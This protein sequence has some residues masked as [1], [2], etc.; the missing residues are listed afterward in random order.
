MQ[1]VLKEKNLNIFANT[2]IILFYQHFQK[3]MKQKE[4]EKFSQTLKKFM[5]GFLIIQ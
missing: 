3:K 1:K 2:E 4:K 5:T